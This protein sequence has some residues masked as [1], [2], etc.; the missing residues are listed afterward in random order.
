MQRNTQKYCSIGRVKV[1][2][3][4]QICSAQHCLHIDVVKFLRCRSI[5]AL[6]EKNYH[7]GRIFRYT[8]KYLEH[9]QNN[10]Q[11]EIYIIMLARNWAEE[12][13]GVCFA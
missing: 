12:Q 11:S 7:S 9:L 10:I 6:H 2:L 3:L 4:E 8:Q 5:F 1:S 13:T